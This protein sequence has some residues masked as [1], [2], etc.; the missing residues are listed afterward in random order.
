MCPCVGLSDMTATLTAALKSIL[1]LSGCMC[2][3]PCSTV[4][5]G[6]NKMEK[7]ILHWGS[8]NRCNLIRENFIQIGKKVFKFPVCKEIT[9]CSRDTVP[10]KSK[11]SIC[12]LSST[13]CETEQPGRCL[14]A[15]LDFLPSLNTFL[16]WFCWLNEGI[17]H[18]RSPRLLQLFS[19]S[20]SRF[21]GIF[22]FHEL[23]PSPT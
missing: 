20:V 11:Q 17:G 9:H 13:N 14:L 5:C 4:V 21:L 15:E 23:N 7:T 8:K 10:L 3:W 6:Q 22:F 19:V 1:R 12:V 18:P 16:C 2:Q